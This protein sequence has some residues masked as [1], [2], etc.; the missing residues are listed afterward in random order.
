MRLLDGFNLAI[1]AKDRNDLGRG[2][3]EAALEGIVVMPANVPES[4]DFG[5][6]GAYVAAAHINI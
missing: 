4:F 2:D 3:V 1:E 5:F 6:F